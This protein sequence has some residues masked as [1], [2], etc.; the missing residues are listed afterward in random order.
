[1]ESV[2]GGTAQL[3]A[4]DCGHGALRMVHTYGFT[5][6]LLAAETSVVG[7]SESAPEP[8]C[9]AGRRRASS[10]R[11][12]TCLCAPRSDSNWVHPSSFCLLPSHSFSTECARC[13]LSLHTEICAAP[14]GARRS[15][16]GRAVLCGCVLCGCVAYIRAHVC[17]AH[18]GCGGV[19]CVCSC[20]VSVCARRRRCPVCPSVR[21]PL[22]VGCAARQV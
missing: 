6:A 15:G 10:P 1:M 3:C 8:H 7:G 21:C 11:V 9:A 2:L 13:Q 20:R 14:L 22:C 17:A 16:E 4:S 5:V 12:T 18:M 19:V